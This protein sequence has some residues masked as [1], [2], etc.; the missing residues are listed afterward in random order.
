MSEAIDQ[1]KRTVEMSKT[2]LLKTF[3]A[4][5]D[6]KL[7]WS[8]SETSK[9]P[10]RI[11]AH[12]GLSNRSLAAMI[13]GEQRPAMSMEEILA[14]REAE[15]KAITTREQAVAL[16]EESVQVYLAALDTVTEERL[17]G[18]VTTPFGVIPMHGFMFMG[19]R[20]MDGHSAQIDYI[21]TIWG[22][23]AFHM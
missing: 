1:A 17:A 10:L 22:D 7:T 15:E 2:R 9:S 21:Q 23:L 13:R 12:S 20:H 16:V 6:D 3:A 8:P 11:V 19:S 4:V 18:T 5:P 14:G